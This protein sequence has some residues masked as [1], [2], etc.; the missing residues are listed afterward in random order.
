MLENQFH[1]LVLHELWS[2]E[3]NVKGKR[4]RWTGNLTKANLHI[5]L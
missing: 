4:C 3:G 1:G 5:V 2:D